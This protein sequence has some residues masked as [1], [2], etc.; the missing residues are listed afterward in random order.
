MQ[1]MLLLLS[2]CTTLAAKAA[3]GEPLLALT[4]GTLQAALEENPLLLLTIGRVGLHG[5]VPRLIPVHGVIGCCGGCGGP[6]CRGGDRVD[7]LAANFAKVTG[8]VVL[9]AVEAHGKQQQR[10]RR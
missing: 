6:G 1:A 2:F 7:A 5:S 10:K 8:I 4:D 3:P 9:I